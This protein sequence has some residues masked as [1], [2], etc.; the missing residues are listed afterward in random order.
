L[1]P[2]SA[3]RIEPIT[4]GGPN[5]SA[6]RQLTVPARQWFTAPNALVKATITRLMGI[7]AFTSY[8]SR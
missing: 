3:P 6:A 4:A 8:P 5:E 2:K 1:R 7:A